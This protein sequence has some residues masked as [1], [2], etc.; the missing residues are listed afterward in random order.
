VNEP[1]AHGFVSFIVLA[2]R[3]LPSL[4]ARFQPFTCSFRKSCGA[5]Q[6]NWLRLVKMVEPVEA[7]KP[8]DADFADAPETRR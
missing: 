4:R 1:F 8:G 6:R 3:E 2:F 5:L 7:F